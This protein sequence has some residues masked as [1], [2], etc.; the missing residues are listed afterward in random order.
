MEVEWSTSSSD[1]DDE[2]RVMYDTRVDRHA[3]Q[4]MLGEM[5]RRRPRGL[6]F[7]HTQPI[8]E[9]SPPPGTGRGAEM[10]VSGPRS[11]EAF[12]VVKKR[13]LTNR[14]LLHVVDTGIPD[15]IKVDA[16]G[17][18]F[19]GCGDGVHV[20]SRDGELLG[21]IKLPGKDPAANLAFGKLNQCQ[22]PRHRCDGSVHT[23]ARASIG[24]RST[25]STRRP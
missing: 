3:C 12:T 4:L 13:I 5:Q 14:R 16:R 19:V 15:G 24:R 18:L 22:A 17:R 7:H 11:V 10:D 25:S 21:K 20:L 2:T 6:V 23:Q 9:A 8:R 1:E